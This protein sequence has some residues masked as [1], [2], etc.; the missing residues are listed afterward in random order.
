MGEIS[1]LLR[2]ETR[3]FWGNIDRNGIV[4]LGSGVGLALLSLVVVVAKFV[5]MN[6]K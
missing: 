1:I 3:E 2:W 5:Y 4:W 6:L